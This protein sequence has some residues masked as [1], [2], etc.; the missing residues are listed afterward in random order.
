MCVMLPWDAFYRI[1]VSQGKVV[2]VWVWVL[3][4]AFTAFGELTQ[5]A[6]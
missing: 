4:I 5:E 6:E 3:C 1:L 2:P